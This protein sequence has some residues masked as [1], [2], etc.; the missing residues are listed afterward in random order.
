MFANLTELTELEVTLLELA[1]EVVRVLL[2]GA[3]T[4]D[5]ELEMALLEEAAF[6]VLALEEAAAELETG[7]EEVVLEEEAAVLEVGSEEV[8][9]EEEE[10]V[11]EVRS[12][13]VV[14]EEAVVVLEA[15]SEEVVLDDV[16]TDEVVVVDE[17]A[18][19]ETTVLEEVVTEEL[20]ADETV[21]DPTDSVLLVITVEEDAVR[22]AVL[23][24]FMVVDFK[25]LLLAADDTVVVYPCATAGIILDEMVETVSDVVEVE[26]DEDEDDEETVLMSGSTSSA[27]SPR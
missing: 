6:S 5:E 14:L 13:E 25:E 22:V 7:S 2:K 11:L 18:S 27:N 9:L 16:A 4:I 1:V 12:E 26:E 19:L 24:G 3:E 8:V 23:A 15:G 17:V 20:E 21:E 10:V